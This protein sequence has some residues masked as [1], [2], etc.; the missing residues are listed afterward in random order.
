MT[1]SHPKTHQRKPHR[2]KPYLGDDSYIHV[3]PIE[4]AVMNKYILIILFAISAC[5]PVKIV[6]TE[7]Y[8]PID[9]STLGTF[10]FGEL[11]KKVK[12]SRANSQK[13]EAF[14]QRLLIEKM[15][16]RGYVYTESEPDLIIDMEV[17]LIDQDRSQPQDQVYGYGRRWP[18]G[19][20]RWNEPPLQDDMPDRGNFNASI[21]LTMGKSADMTGLWKGTAEAQLSRNQR[22]GAERLQAAMDQLLDRFEGS[23][24]D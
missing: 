2:D 11:S 8:G 20:Y 9:Y 15:E 6:S 10:G 22:K 18:Y 12:V 1:F 3:Q 17:F 14:I 5:Q 16:E 7:R 4:P 23:P 13:T 24:Q 19:G 21:S